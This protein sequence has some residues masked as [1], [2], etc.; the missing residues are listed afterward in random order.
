MP[1]LCCYAL[2]GITESCTYDHIYSKLESCCPR[3]GSCCMSGLHRACPSL[4]TTAF[5][6]VPRASTP[7]PGTSPGCYQQNPRVPDGPVCGTDSI[8]SPH[9]MLPK[10]YWLA[11]QS[12]QRFGEI[13]L[14]VSIH[15]LLSLPGPRTESV[16]IWAWGQCDWPRSQSPP[17]VRFVPE[18]GPATWPSSSHSLRQGQMILNSKGGDIFS[19]ELGLHLT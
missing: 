7:L 8:F 19:L 9:Q 15:S 16:E 11:L 14:L 13:G 3:A 1:F 4:Q 17:A 6:T 5:R 10:Q 2:L 18:L 12:L